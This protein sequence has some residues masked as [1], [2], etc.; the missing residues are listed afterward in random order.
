MPI[1]DPPQD[2]SRYVKPKFFTEEKTLQRAGGDKRVGRYSSWRAT[3]ADNK[4]TETRRFPGNE[5]RPSCFH[6]STQGKSGTKNLLVKRG[7]E[8]TWYC[9]G[10]REVDPLSMRQKYLEWKRDTPV[11][12][13]TAV[14]GQNNQQLKTKASALGNPKGIVRKT[15]RETF[16]NFLRNNPV[17]FGPQNQN[18]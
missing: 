11:E 4:R 8:E 6:V 16:Y 2:N 3:K 5:Q 1:I 13:T 12:R 15:R 14:R 9:R 18:Q 7:D 17:E 10:P